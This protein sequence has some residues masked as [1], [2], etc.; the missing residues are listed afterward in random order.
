MLKLLKTPGAVAV[1]NFFLPGLGYLMLGIKT[2]FAWLLIIS[3]VFGYYW[4]FTDP[5]ASSSTNFAFIAGA[6][7]LSLAF[8][9]DGY[10]EAKA[11]AK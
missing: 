10:Q 3:T 7:L 8:A 9:F 6:S 5:S 1:M 2:V 4:Y 11:H